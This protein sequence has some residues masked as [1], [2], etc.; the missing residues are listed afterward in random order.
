MA[1]RKLRAARWVCTTPS[2]GGV[3]KFSVGTPLHKDDTHFNR[4]VAVFTQSHVKFTWLHSRPE[5]QP[6]KSDC[7]LFFC[8]KN[9]FLLCV[10]QNCENF[11]DV[12]TLMIAGDFTVIVHKG[13]THKSIWI[14]LQ[15]H[16]ILDKQST[17]V[18]PFYG[19][20]EPQLHCTCFLRMVAEPGVAHAWLFWL[21]VEPFGS[22]C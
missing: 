6:K 16:S 19:S 18:R 4:D 13:D 1:A 11:L 2:W 21:E 8:R 14:P 12:L 5:V 15:F 20:K 10:V 22:G 3:W 17:D 7:Q 9:I